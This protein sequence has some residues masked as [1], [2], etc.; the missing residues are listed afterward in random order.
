MVFVYVLR[1]LMTRPWC[2]PSYRNETRPTRFFNKVNGRC[3]ACIR[4]VAEDQAAT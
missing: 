2:I 4:T 1:K 3:M